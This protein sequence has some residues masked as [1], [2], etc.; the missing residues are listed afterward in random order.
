MKVIKD[1]LTEKARN[2]YRELSGEEKNIEREYGRNKYH[3]SKEKKQKLYNIHKNVMKL[4]GLSLVI[5]NYIN[6]VVYA[7]IQSNT[8]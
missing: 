1:I 3:M 4:K 8:I 7:M 5:N 6:L 2:K